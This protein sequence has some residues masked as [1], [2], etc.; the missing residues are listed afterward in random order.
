MALLKLRCDTAYYT[1]AI[2]TNL[3]LAD[4][5]RK[6]NRA[7]IAARLD[8]GGLVFSYARD[9]WTFV[10][11]QPDG[12]GQIGWLQ[13]QT[14]GDIGG[15]SH[16]LAM[17]NVRHWFEHSRPHDVDVTDVRCVTRYTYRWDGPSSATAAD[18]KPSIETYDEALA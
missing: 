7:K 6:L 1:G 5:V 10:D 15:L 4:L 9:S 18:T 8:K 17:L 2:R 16:K 12:L 11:W 3:S 14:E 13:F